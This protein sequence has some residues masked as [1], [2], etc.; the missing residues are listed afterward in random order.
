[1]TFIVARLVIHQSRRHHL[2][3]AWTSYW[4]RSTRLNAYSSLSSTSFHSTTM[5]QHD[6]VLKGKYPARSHCAK[7]A[8]YLKDKVK[9]DSPARIYLQGQKTRMIEDNDE[10]Q[11]FRSRYLM[12][13]AQI[14]ADLGHPDSVVIFSIS[15]AA[16][17]QTAI[18]FTTSLLP[19][20]PSSSHHSTPPRSFG[21]VCPF[22]QTKLYTSTMS[23]MFALHP[24]STT[25]SRPLENP[26]HPHP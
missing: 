16:I 21:L 26:D 24:N 25:T 10:P 4:S 18:L 22:L 1:M 3:N 15:L 13:K 14:P 19:L 2:I 5:N 11:P 17:C 8:A 7:V 9:D 6:S 23:T 20:S 12:A